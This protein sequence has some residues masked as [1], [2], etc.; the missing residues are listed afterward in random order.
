MLASRHGTEKNKGNYS[1]DLSECTIAFS[2]KKSAIIVKS[3]SVKD[4]NAIAFH[5]YTIE[6]TMPEFSKMLSCIS[7]HQIEE[8]GEVERILSS[9]IHDLL[10]IA[11]H[12]AKHLTSQNSTKAL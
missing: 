6:I 5:D 10:K 3:R 4:F 7:S 1:I 12:A 9:N 8:G 2:K 11:T